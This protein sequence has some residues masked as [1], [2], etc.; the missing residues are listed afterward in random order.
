MRSVSFYSNSDDVLK[1]RRSAFLF[2]LLL[3]IFTNFIFLFLEILS[4]YLFLLINIFLIIMFYDTYFR[5]PISWKLHF[6]IDDNLIKAG[7]FSY[8]WKY[9]KCYEVIREREKCIILLKGFLFDYVF[10]IVVPV[11][12]NLCKKVLSI[13]SSKLPE[14]KKVNKS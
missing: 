5:H 10:P 12:K 14:E 4:F 9:F 7:F 1:Y 6:Y 8:K 13:I 2:I 11:R 3:I